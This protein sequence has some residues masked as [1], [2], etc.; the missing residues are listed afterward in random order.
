MTFFGMFFLVLSCIAALILFY[1]FQKIINGLAG[2]TII[3]KWLIVIFIPG[4]LIAG[5]LFLDSAGARTPVQVTDKK[6]SITNGKYGSWN[7][8]F[9]VQIKYQSPRELIPTS[10]TVGSDAETFDSLHVGQTVEARILDYGEY[11]KFARLGNRTTLSWFQGLLPRSPNGPWRQANATVSYVKEVTRYTDRSGTSV[12]RWPF[13]VVELTFTPEGRQE[14]VV[15]VDVVEAAS[16]P[17][18]K[19]GDVRPIL[20]AEDVPREA[21]IVGARP[22]EPFKNWLYSIGEYI[23]II[24]GFF[25][26]IAIVS[27]LFRRRKKSRLQVQPQNRPGY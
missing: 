5:S 10:L 26:L 15:A 18:L 17:G 7:R 2:R 3:P 1:L 12:I 14:N 27:M 9:K 22:G 13:D 19:K 25:V 24:L 21:R 6:E 4:A 16:V 20:Y 8:T 23:A 11:L